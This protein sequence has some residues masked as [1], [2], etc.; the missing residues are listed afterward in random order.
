[1]SEMGRNVD[2][3]GT[4]STAL[5]PKMAAIGIVLLFPLIG[6]YF[7]ITIAFGLAA[8]YAGFVFLLYWAGL[9]GA[10]NAEIA[11]AMIGMIAAIGI[12]WMLHALPTTMGQAGLALPLILILIS[13]FCL[14]CGWLPMLF[15]QGFM[16]MLTIGGIAPLAATNPYA[17]MAAC[18]VIGTAYFGGLKLAYDAY[19]RSRRTN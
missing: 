4:P 16:L 14:M 12:C 19:A 15:N 17:D 13:V 8:T 10:R 6:A 18:V 7:A 9:R 11:P 5:S 2:P 3:E 1:M